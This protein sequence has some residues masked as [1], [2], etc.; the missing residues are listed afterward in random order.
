MYLQNIS[1]YSKRQR[2]LIDVVAVVVEVA[3]H[4]YSVE[5]LRVEG[6]RVDFFLGRALEQSPVEVGNASAEKEDLH[7]VLGVFECRG[8]LVWIRIMVCGLRRKC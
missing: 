5:W 1:I 3:R 2:R 6:A 7:R 8:V 4:G